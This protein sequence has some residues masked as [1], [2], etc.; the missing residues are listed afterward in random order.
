VITRD[1]YEIL[2]VSRT[3]S[4]DEIKKAYRRLAL[5]YHPDRNP[6]DPEAEQKFKEV[7]DAYSVLSDQEKRAIYDRYGHEGL[8]GQAGAG[9]SNVEDIFSSFSDIFGDLF[10][11]GSRRGARG[12]RGLQG[13]HIRTE[14][15]LTLKEAAFG[16]TKDV[17]FKR[18]EICSTCSGSGAKPGTTPETCPLCGGAGAI[19]ATQGIFRVQQTCPK[20]R[21]AGHQIKEKCPDCRGSGRTVVE[22]TNSIP[23]QA[24]VED[25]MQIRVS[26]RGEPGIN[27]GPPGDLYVLVHVRQDK[28]FIREGA[29]LHYELPISFAQAAL[30]AEVEVPTLQE[31]ESLTIPRG[32]QTGERFVLKGKGVQMLQR[33]SRGDLYVHVRVVTP[34][35]LSRKEEELLRALAEEAGENVASRSKMRDFFSKIKP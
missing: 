34:T 29:D 4:G 5:T 1:Y 23:I 22:H 19:L 15:V 7:S 31:P 24:G 26:G 28:D 30:G 8:K 16:T 35:N 33:P 21:G 18:H 13:E 11:M 6:D 10:G 3:A 25:G 12:R 9:F 27:G 17:T 2:G 32:T 20:C 14:V